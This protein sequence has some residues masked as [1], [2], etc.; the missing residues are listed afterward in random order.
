MAVNGLITVVTPTVGNG[1]PRRLLYLLREMRQ[2][3]SLSYE[4]VVCDDGT[5]SP[6]VHA[7]QREICKIYGVK[8]ILNTGPHFGASFALNR[9]FA[10]V[11]TRWAYIV[12]DGCRPSKQWLEAAV[13]FIRNTGESLWCQRRIAMAGIPALPQFLLVMGDVFGNDRLA[14][15]YIQTERPWKP[16]VVEDFYGDWNDGEWSWERLYP[17]MQ[18]R[19]F[20]HPNPHPME[21]SYRDMLLRQLSKDEGPE[22]Q[23]FR[24]G[25]VER[26]NPNHIGGFWPRRRIAET[27]YFGTPLA[28]I[29]MELFKKAGGFRDYCWLYEG[30]LAMRFGLAGHLVLTAEQPPWLHLSNQASFEAVHDG[31]QPRPRLVDEIFLRE[32]GV[33]P[34]HAYHSIDRVIPVL[35]KVEINKALAQNPIRELP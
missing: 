20:H 2:F 27:S 24:E 18:K 13:E 29:N 30:H 21:L 16:F 15:D 33:D 17:R 6:G 31:H 9:A 14:D 12:D 5:I 26:V 7:I 22:S 11:K 28:L 35:E 10:E 19:L 4:H 34:A 23:S 8:F 25:V 3:T 32:F 1:S